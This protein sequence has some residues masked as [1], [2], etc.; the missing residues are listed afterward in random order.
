MKKLFAGILILML[1]MFA[2]IE[3]YAQC[4]FG[5]KVNCEG[6]CGRFTD[7]DGDSFCDFGLKEAPKA[8][9]KNVEQTTAESTEPI[10]EKQETK[11][12]IKPKQTKPQQEQAKPLEIETAGDE[13]ATA[14]ESEQTTLSS[15]QTI[16]EQ[17]P[18]EK[19]TTPKPY[20]V[21][22]ISLFCL[23][24]YLLTY[25]SVKAG[26]MKKI[27]HRKIWNAILLIT[28]LMSCLLGFLLAVQLNYRFGMSWFS[29]ILKLHVEFGIAMTI[30]AFFHVVWHLKYYKNLF[31]K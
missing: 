8:E 21:I 22:L 10:A 28:A 9:N 20:N 3:T 11:Q 15:T 1:G 24:A 30:V 27:T 6:A 5:D 7:E 31:K 25:I 29:P 26:K 19:K 2:S 13:V 12:T 18:S 17:K 16:V 4:P 23:A 14:Q